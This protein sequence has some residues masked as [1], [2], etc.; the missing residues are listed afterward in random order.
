MHMHT[1][2]RFPIASLVLALAAAGASAQTGVAWVEFA[3]QPDTL[4]FGV[5]AVSDVNT[6]VD[7]A[8]GDLDQDGWLDVV[9]A[10]KAQGSMLTKHADVLLMN[11]QGVLTDQTA[12]YASASDVPG[13][14]GFL[15]PCVHTA[16]KLAD[17]DMDGWLDV[18]FSSALSD[19]DPK[20]ISHPRVYRNLADD[21]AGDW[22]GL[23]FENGR[24]PQLMTVAGMAVAPR[25][26]QFDAGDVTG[27]GAPDLYFVD[28]DST[29]TGIT[30]TSSWDLNDRLLVNDGNGYFFDASSGSLTLAQLKSAFGLNARIIDLN[31]DGA[32]DLVKL[33]YLANPTGLFAIYNDP[34]NL[35]SFL[36]GGLQSIGKSGAI[37]GFTVG[38]LNGDALPDLAIADCAS[39]GFQ[40]GQGHDGLNHLT[41][42]PKILF[43][44]VT[45]GD[46]GFAQNVVLSDLDL[47]GWNDVL[48]TDVDADLTGCGRRMH[49]YHNTGSV[50]G[51]QDL[52]IKEESELATGAQGA[53]WKGVV[54]IS[55]AKER[56]TYA[57]AA[58]D[59]DLDG[60]PD[61]L[62]GRCAGMSYFQNE[63][64]HETCQTDLGFGGPGT[65][66]LSLCGDDLTQAGSLAT[67]QLEGAPANQPL[68]LVLSLTAGAAPFKG[69]TL[70]PV[71]I[72]LLVSGFVTDGA[73]AFGTPVT[74]A[75]GTPV[76]IIMQA[77]VKDG[78][79]WAISNALDVLMGV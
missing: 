24:I 64:I 62:V 76:D 59:F 50:P 53:G 49:I 60:D 56:G 47:N 48:I 1:A 13:D 69:G 26:A 39:D 20:V 44:Y 32:Q 30:E 18:I 7:F 42:G 68:V 78:S 11:L 29:E 23:R 28:F 21:G 75:A 37:D 70:V 9:V 17:V 66:T 3:E 57:V 36:A 63:T 27:D 35:G 2:R 33:S 65:A 72:L 58:A 67:L 31:G 34:G 4:G 51:E 52:V 25:F 55:A 16:V 19:G 46:D 43:Q 45:G 38:D 12:L 71:P 5:A 14:Q 74:G 79:A 10:R 8:T 54:G 40:L 22:Q 73:G 77:L 41:T 15:T 6:D 61:L